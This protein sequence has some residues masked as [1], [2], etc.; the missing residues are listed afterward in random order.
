MST[1]QL[2]RHQA[3]WSEFLFCFNYRITYHPGKAGGKSDTLTYQSGD[4]LRE[5]D[6]SDPCHL[7]QHQTVL[8]SHVLDPRILKTQYQ[9]I[10]LNPIQLHLFLIQFSFF[11]TLAF[12]NFDP[13]EFNSDDAESQLN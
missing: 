11:V 12:M 8:K 1:K 9:S 13:E 10:T 5:G 3:H 7:Y 6:I 4:L 2:S